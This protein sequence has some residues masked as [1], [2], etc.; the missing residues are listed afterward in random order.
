[1]GDIRRRFNG[2]FPLDDG[3][4]VAGNVIVEDIW[5][6]APVRPNTRA[7]VTIGE[8]GGQMTVHLR[9]DGTVMSSAASEQFLSEFVERL[10]SGRR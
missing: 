1:M 8:Y 2:R 4:W 6:V 9:T 10:V 5:G 3:R 7:A